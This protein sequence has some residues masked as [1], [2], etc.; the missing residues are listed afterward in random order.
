MKGRNMENNRRTQSRSTPRIANTDKCQQRESEDFD[1]DKFYNKYKRIMPSRGD[2]PEAKKDASIRSKCGNNLG[3][4]FFV[5]NMSNAANRNCNFRTAIWT[6]DHIQCTL[7]SIAKG[8][9]IGLEVHPNTDQYIRV[10]SGRG[11]VSVGRSRDELE[12]SQSISVG[13][14]A[15]IP[16]GVWHNIKNTGHQP[17]RLSSV[18]APPYHPKCTVQNVKEESEY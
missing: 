17:L 15:F 18:Y 5:V 14:A 7:M 1:I 3:G 9:D 13:D 6:G 10:E 8:E 2:R 12:N 16:A 11:I 4:S